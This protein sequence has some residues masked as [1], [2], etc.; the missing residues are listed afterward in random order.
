MGFAYKMSVYGGD[1]NKKRKV[2][3]RKGTFTC[4]ISLSNFAVWCDLE[5]ND[6]AKII[7]RLYSKRWKRFYFLAMQ[8]N[9]N[10]LDTW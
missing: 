10:V 7:Q 6:P 8:M 2:C 9:C 3:K 1:R 4:P 5:R